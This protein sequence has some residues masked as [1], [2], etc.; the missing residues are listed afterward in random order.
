MSSLSVNE[1]A[2]YI[3]SKASLR[4]L[5]SLCK[6]TGWKFV[7]DPKTDPPEYM[8]FVDAT[9]ITVLLPTTEQDI[10]NLGL[11]ILTVEQ[12]IKKIEIGEEGEDE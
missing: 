9:G 7:H 6:K 5:K 1:N 2:V 12:L 10:R 3:S 11:F 8:R 4:R